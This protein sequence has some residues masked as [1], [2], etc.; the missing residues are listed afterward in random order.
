[1]P[2]P[3]LI[4]KIIHTLEVGAGSRYLRYATFAVIVL[5]LAF[6]YD[7]RAYRNFSTSEAMDAAQLAHNISEGKGYTTLFIR[8]FSLYL[9][10]RHNQP[11]SV[12]SLVDTN[13][14]FARIK[15]AHPDLANAPVYPVFLAGLMKILPF[16]YAVNLKSSFWANNGNFWRYQPDFLI[17]VI[18]EILLIIAT[19]L[20]FVLAKNLFDASVARLT[21]TLML[22]CELL[23]RFSISGLSTTLLLV[24]F[25]GLT[26]CILKI[27]K[28]SREPQPA[29]GR[30]LKFAL[31][32][33]VLAGLG[34]L[35]RYAF[36]F[37]IIPVIL[38]LILF[39]GQ[40]RIVQATSTLGAFLIV[41]TP[42]IIRNFII[43]GTFFGTAGYAIF[44]GTG[45]RLERSL[46][47]DFSNVFSAGALAHKLVMNLRDILSDVLPR[48][49]G[50]W[51]SLLFLAGLLL[52]F[53]NVAIQRMRYFLLMCLGIFIIV[54]ALGRTQLSDESPEV[55]SENLLVLLIPLIFIYGTSFF[56]T[57]LDQMKLPLPRLRYVVISVFI[58]VCCVP[59]IS[60]VL[61][62]TRP[63]AYPP[64]YPPEIQTVSGWMKENE[65]MMSD[66]PWAMAWYGNHQCVWL[67][68]DWQDDFNAISKNMKPVQALYLTPKTM[69]G[70]FVT[71]W[72]EGSEHSWGNFLFQ[73]LDQNRTPNNFPLTKAP[74]GYFPERMFLTDHQRW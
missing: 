47:P 35:T 18:N 72:M 11:S 9:V 45:F 54:Q 10:Q 59:M 57:F 69:D 60:G 2:L 62:K 8:P 12:T 43:S 70:K 27:E 29:G 4:Q 52:G 23:W 71:E 68:L 1:M 64:Y 44:E 5:G 56:F 50:S 33:G 28:T 67:T 36:G 32:A 65:L 41:L 15:T 21:V 20:T 37:V 40:R 63:V 48:L 6:F 66:V 13:Q 26:W 39:G 3:E 31:A 42:W 58:T 19:A 34:A 24:I 53:R 46:Q 51:A 55:N 17:A 49:G 16:H 73:V 7:I 61:F 38:F 25:L 74:T 14:D 30:L 22:G